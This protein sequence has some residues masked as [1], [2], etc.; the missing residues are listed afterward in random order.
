MVWWVQTLAQRKGAVK[1]LEERWYSLSPPHFS[2][3]LGL[4]STE[5]KIF[6]W[7]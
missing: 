2:F 6:Q 1:G 3:L 5:E 4:K 7:N